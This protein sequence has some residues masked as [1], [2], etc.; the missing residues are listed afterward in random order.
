MTGTAAEHGTGA[1]TQAWRLFAVELAARRQLSPTSSGSRSPARSWTRSP[2]T[3]STSG[4]SWCSRRQGTAS[5]CHRPV[6]TGTRTGGRCRRSGSARPGPTPC[7]R[8]G[9]VGPDARYAGRH[10]GVEF[11]PGVGV[12]TVLL[13]GDETA[14]P[15]IMSIV[16]R[17]PSGTGGEVLLKVPHD[18]DVLPVSAPAVADHHLARAPRPRARQ[19]AR[20]RGAG[21]GRATRPRN[22]RPGHAYR[23]RRRRRP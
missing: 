1:R 4:S 14:V 11:Q 9:L 8:S 3:G 23:P 16:E 20:A 18:Q 22:C 19:P 12:H 10:G 21:G 2:T 15:A 17:L 6:W 13:A 7:A 5:S